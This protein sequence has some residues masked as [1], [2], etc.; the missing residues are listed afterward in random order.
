MYFDVGVMTKGL[1]TKKK[2]FFNVAILNLDKNIKIGSYYFLV[3]DYWVYSVDDSQ[4][5]SP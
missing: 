4:C 3:L 1:N 2:K 5:F